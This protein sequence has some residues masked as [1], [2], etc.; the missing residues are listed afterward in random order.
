MRAGFMPGLWRQTAGKQPATFLFLPHV[1]IVPGIA[2]GGVLARRGR[3]RAL[4]ELIELQGKL[5][6][7]CH[8][9]LEHALPAGR[10]PECGTPYDPG[11]LKRGWCRTY[12]NLGYEIDWPTAPAPPVRQ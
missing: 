6:L 3:R 9:K 12:P 4:R 7:R 11:S 10:C 2:V 8:Y 1:M 5:C